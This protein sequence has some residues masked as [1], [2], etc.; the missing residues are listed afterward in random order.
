VISAALL[1]PLILSGKHEVLGMIGLAT[2]FLAAVG[3]ASMAARTMG[4]SSLGRILC[5]IF[6]I[7]PIV[8]A[9]PALLLLT[10]RQS[11]SEFPQSLTND[12]AETVQAG[13][14]AL[15]TVEVPPSLTTVNGF[16]FKLY[17]RSGYDP[18]TDS[19][20]TTHY[21]VALFLPLLPIGRYRVISEDGYRYQFL[22][23][24]SLRSLDR[25]HIAIVIAAVLLMVAKAR[26]TG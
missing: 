22:G 26:G 20:M 3:G 9:L 16:G 25:V 12:E 5:L 1:L 13:D 11:A 17:G 21:L 14:E 15:R 8:N 24:A 10:K 6:S 4:L 19:Y 23:R 7:V 18:E 2:N